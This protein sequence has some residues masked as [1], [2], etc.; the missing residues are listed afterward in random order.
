MLV[1]VRVQRRFYRNE[2]IKDLKSVTMIQIPSYGE[3]EIP[4]LLVF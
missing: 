2:G 3:F 1:E 4:Q